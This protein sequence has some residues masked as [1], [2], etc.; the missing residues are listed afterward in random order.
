[1]GWAIGIGLLAVAAVSAWMNR[2]LQE[3]KRTNDLLEIIGD[4]LTGPHQ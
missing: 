3:A 4:R 2:M 1:M